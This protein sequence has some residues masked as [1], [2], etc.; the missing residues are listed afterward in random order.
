MRS[1]SRTAAWLYVLAV[2]VRLAALALA[3]NEDGDAMAR[4]LFARAVADNADLVPSDAWLPGHFVFLAL[5]G[6]LAGLDDQLSMLVLTVAVSSLAVPFL[7]WI[8]APFFGW[9][10]AF[11]SGV[12]LACLGI[13]VRFSVV[14]MA[15]GPSI[16]AFLLSFLM[17]MRYSDSGRARELFVGAVSMA[18]SASMRYESW[19]LPL[20]MCGGTILVEALRRQLDGARIARVVRFGA[21][22]LLFPAWWTAYSFWRFGDPFFMQSQIAQYVQDNPHPLPAVVEAATFWPGLVLFAMGPVGLLAVWSAAECLRERSAVRYLAPVG[23][24]VVTLMATYGGFLTAR[25]GLLPLALLCGFVGPGVDRLGLLSPFTAGRLR[26]QGVVLAAAALWLPLIPA[27]VALETGWLSQRAY[28]VSALPKF[29]GAIVSVDDFLRRHGARDGAIVV[30]STAGSAGQWLSLADRW[31]DIQRLSEYVDR[32]VHIR[33][34]YFAQSEEQIAAIMAERR[35]GFL[36]VS[37]GGAVRVPVGSPSSP[38]DADCRVSAEPVFSTDRFE[39]FSWSETGLA[40]ANA[41]DCTR[42]F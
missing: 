3:D 19:V 37:R 11:V 1:D 7:Y 27:V 31:Y 5:P 18:V 32:H 21:A 24:I 29:D 36:V 28:A 20:A 4:V 22:S 14:T 12:V 30:A 9:R 39:V 23:A 40:L 2:V 6:L 35:R 41:A 10:A 34:L 42:R 15:E 13:H 16:A 8:T 33:Q 26:V 38:S 17:F 25:Y